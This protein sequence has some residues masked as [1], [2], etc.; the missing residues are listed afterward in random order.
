MV[1]GKIEV[2]V[3]RPDRHFFQTVAYIRIAELV[4]PDRGG[5]VRLDRN[6][7]YAFRL[8]VVGQFFDAGFA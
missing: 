1:A 4:Q 2:P 6:Q 3:C 8:V 5:V 7:R